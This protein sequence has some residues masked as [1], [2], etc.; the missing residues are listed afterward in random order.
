[1]TRA[2]VCVRHHARYVRLVAQSAVAGRAVRRHAGGGAE[3]VELAGGRAQEAH[4][5]VVA[6][7]ERT[8][9]VGK[10]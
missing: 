10:K 4:A 1:L 6:E 2:S 8:P 3:G 7:I 5:A 9:A